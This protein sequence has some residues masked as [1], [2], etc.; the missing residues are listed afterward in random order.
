MV[1]S[2][3]PHVCHPDASILATTI[4]SMHLCVINI[5]LCCVLL[6]KTEHNVLS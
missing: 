3:V 4:Y 2:F 5:F 6:T 1:A